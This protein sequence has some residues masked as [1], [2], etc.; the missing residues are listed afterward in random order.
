M[1]RIYAD[2][3]LIFDNTIDDYK[4]GK[5]EVTRETNKSGS[6]VFSLYPD[7]PHYD[8]FIRLATIIRV[9]KRDKIVFR[10][11]ILNDVTD[12]WNNKVFTC[13]GELS[14]LNDS[15]VRPFSFSGSPE[16]F[17]K[18][19]I[20]AHNAQV[21]ES[22][23]FKIGNVT[24]IDSNDTITRNS[25]LYESTLS[26]LT[27]RTIGSD[28]GGYLA[29]THGDDGRD[30]IPTIHW[31]KDFDR[32]SSQ[33]IE[34]GVNL[35][36]YT[37]TIKAD[38]IATAIIPLGADIEGAEGEERKKLTISSVNDG[39]DYIYSQEAVDVYG[40]IFKTVEF[41][42]IT[43]ASN[44]KKRAEEY[45]K[46]IMLHTTTIELN[47]IDLNLLNPEIESIEINEYIRAVSTP[48]RFDVVLLCSKQTI[49]LLKPENDS[50]VLGYT[51]AT[52][53][54]T[55][56]SNINMIGKI[57]SNVSNKLSD[58]LSNELLAINTTIDQLT[59]KVEESPEVDLEP[60]VYRVFGT[61]DK[62]TVNLV[63]KDDELIHEY[64]FEFVPSD[65]FT[66]LVITPEIKWANLPQYPTGKVCQVSILRGV[67]VFVCA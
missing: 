48:H 3:T 52:F 31:L 59:I 65:L 46:T 5:G 55:N 41:S 25:T 60:D 7:H 22:K 13:E 62:L 33:K 15:I 43:L 67:G 38:T 63:P 34:F 50:I 4:I 23:R 53:T 32:V 61:V 66:E 54:G 35:K 17:F 26:S 37:R 1:Y 28:L 10:G 9:Y 42:D 18:Q 40:W 44:L 2:D 8:S 58:R 39:V 47:A 16:A 24:V 36:K 14:F 64:T 20:E 21:D 12:H 30:P 27:S 6:F 56:T 29:I 45:L 57:T 19:S 49:N 51:L 11:R